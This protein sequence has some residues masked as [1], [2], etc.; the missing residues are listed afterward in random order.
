MWLKSF[1]PSLSATFNQEIALPGLTDSKHDLKD[2]LETVVSKL[3][4]RLLSDNGE[5]EERN[6]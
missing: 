3:Q 1:Y 2:Y 4:Q 5:M 6:L